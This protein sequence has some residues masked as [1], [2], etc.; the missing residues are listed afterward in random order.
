MNGHPGRELLDAY[1]HGSLG[2]PAATAV[3]FHLPTCS[4]CQQTV[5]L[6]SEWDHLSWAQIAVGIRLPPPTR[7]EQGLTHLGVGEATSRLLLRT[8]ALRL[9]WLIALSFTLVFSAVAATLGSTESS[10]IPFLVAAPLAPLIGVALAYSQPSDPIQQIT[11]VAPMDP[12]KLLLIR[13]SA[14]SATALAIAAIA[15]LVLI[16]P[17]RSWLWI[18][19]ALTLTVLTLAVGTYLHVSSAAVGVGALWLLGVGGLA[20]TGDAYVLFRQ[21]GWMSVVLVAALLALVLRRDSYRILHP[22]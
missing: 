8:P 4:K 7:I 18:L 12:F 15:D 22:R 10:L 17:D 2:E 16:P 13:T 20:I 5:R 3:E 6:S 1:R 19:P 14:V 11:A 21:P 9:P